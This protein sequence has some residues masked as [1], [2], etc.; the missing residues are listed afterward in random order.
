MKKMYL[1]LSMTVVL[2]CCTEKNAPGNDSNSGGNDGNDTEYV[3]AYRVDSIHVLGETTLERFVYFYTGS[4]TFSDSLHVFDYA[5]NISTSWC[6]YTFVRDN[7]QRVKETIYY[8][9]D[10]HGQLS[11]GVRSENEFD[12]QDR[13]TRQ[14]SYSWSDNEWKPARDIY[15]R[16]F[17]TYNEYTLS[18]V[19]SYNPIDHRY[20]KYDFFYTGDRKDSL[21]TYSKK[22]GE[23]YGYPSKTVYNRVQGSLVYEETSYNT[24]ITEDSYYF[25]PSSKYI[26][27]YDSHNT[28]I[29]SEF[30][31]WRNNKWIRSY[32]GIFFYDYVDGTDQVKSYTTEGTWYDYEGKV[33]MTQKNKGTYFLSSIKVKKSIASRVSIFNFIPE[34]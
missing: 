33:I 29:K 19:Y 3:D 13:T 28:N 22:E 20:L 14:K 31:G 10:Q 16:D 25:E 24:V 17:N 12:N 6:R 11:S 4:G 18:E 2:C 8:V 1:L 23:S 30:Y 34:Y 32:I 15:Y 27:D 5:N 7:K 21:Y 26:R 9:Y